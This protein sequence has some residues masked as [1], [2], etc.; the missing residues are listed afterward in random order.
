MCGLYLEFH[1]PINMEGKS[2]R[3]VMIPKWKYS[4]VV[5]F[6]VQVNYC[7]IPRK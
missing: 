3:I 4:Y 6:D 5:I 2:V 7:C 1:K